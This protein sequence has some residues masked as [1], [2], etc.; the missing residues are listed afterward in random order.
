MKYYAIS[1]HVTP[2]SQD[3]CD[4]LSAL[5]GEAGC[6]SFAD[7]TDGLEAYVQ[8]QL[9]DQHLLDTLIADFP[10]ADT[11]ISYD[12]TEVE[13]RDWNEAWEQEGF[14]PIVIPS[15]MPT[16]TR[17]TCLIIHD[18]R[19]LPDTTADTA[20]GLQ[21]EIDTRQ[22]FGTGTHETTRMIC[23]LLL[24]TELEGKT[25]LDCGCGT[26]ILSI[27]ALKLGAARCT[28]YDI[29]EW[30]T[31]N[32]RHNAV[33]NQVEQSLTIMHGDAS[34][35]D[36]MNQPFDLVAANINRN[37]LLNDMPRFV[38]VMVPTAQL[39]LSGFYVSDCDILQTA[40]RQLGLT[41]VATRSD[42]QWACMVFRK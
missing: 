18:G 17:P 29:D 24:E 5:A 34:L 1:F 26:G 23:A 8:Q 12:M 33:I 13:D 41:H 38:R 21:I 25:V 32:T 35:T 39:I 9:F 15:P 6:E 14:P 19:H 2:C 3:A 37:I 11:H 42:G 36:G 20:R 7:S 30:S 16:A 40:A 27:C 22:A 31:E 4:I 10:L 28:A